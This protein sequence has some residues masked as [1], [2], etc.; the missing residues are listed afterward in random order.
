MKKK[1]YELLW[2]VVNDDLHTIRLMCFFTAGAFFSFALFTNDFP[3]RG[4]IPSQ[5]LSFFPAICAS[6]A[7]L[8]MTFTRWGADNRQM[9]IKVFV[10]SLNLVDVYFLYATEHQDVY[11][12]QFII[13]FVVSA[14]FFSSRRDL[15]NF[16][17]AV[18]AGVIITAFT[19]HAHSM[20]PADFYLTF[21][22]SEIIFFVL[23]KF[24]IATEEKLQKS[25]KMYRLLADNSFD[26]ICIH[27]AKARLQFISPSI[28]KLLGYEPDEL[29]G[30]YPVTV[31][32]PDDAHIMLGLDFR[33]PSHPFM[34]KPV[35]FRI[36]D[37]NGEYS[38]F[39]TVFTRIEDPGYENGIVISQ[40]RDIK[41]SKKYQQQ[42]EERTRELERSNADL[43]TFA[44]V[45]SHDMQEP[46]RMI[47]NYTQLLKRRYDGKLDKDADE[48]IEYANRGA[49]NLQ[50]IIKD[51]LSYSRINRTEIRKTTINMNNLI[52]DVMQNIQV[53]LI[54]RNARVVYSDLCKLEA[55][56]TQ[57]TLVMQ[58]L[59]LNGIKYNES[60]SPE[61]KVTWTVVGSDITFCI[62]DNGIGIDPKYHLRIF[63]PFHRLHTRADYPGTGLGLSICKRVVE[64]M[65]G[66]IWLESKVGQ[67]S[68]FYFT[69]P[70]TGLSASMPERVFAKVPFFTSN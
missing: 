17:I 29:L 61:V 18:N 41:R 53:D 49:V 45:S 13:G 44:F 2:K 3:V 26:L 66:S 43:E 64:R 48:Y 46:L 4:I 12:Y 5:V 32:H 11:A 16:A 14:Y 6:L 47:S 51:L 7:F 39:E 27:D 25:E 24:R 22:G 56:P 21:I 52:G 15:R 35:Q 1:L 55:D 59:I 68:K 54:E 50:Q 63:E 10:Y 65:G 57:M 62:A 36:R 42:L 31:V 19:S 8:L 40:S 70:Y 69:L 23:Y 34:N 60:E 9:L 30:K 67:G 58:N 28:E 38:W 20:S 37:K 33:D